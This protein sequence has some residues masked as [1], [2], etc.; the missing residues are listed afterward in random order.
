M[1]SFGVA[2]IIASLANVIPMFAMFKDMKP[3]EKII[4]VAFAV[5]AA[6]VLGDHL[7]FTA[8]V[9][10]SFITP[11]LVGKLAGGIFAF[12]LALFF[13]RNKNL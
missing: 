10:A 5:C 9:N 6:F 1:S 4:N 11:V 2:G 12:S 7:G 8:A 13:T 3:R